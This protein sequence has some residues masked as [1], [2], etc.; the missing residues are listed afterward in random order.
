[1]LFQSIWANKLNLS[2]IYNRYKMKIA[3]LTCQNLPNLNLSDQQLIPT[4]A[5]HNIIATAAIWDDKSINWTL[6]DYLLFRNTWDYYEKENQF[7]TWLNHIQSLGIKTLNAIEII[8]KNKHKFYL[9]D[10]YNQ[11]ITILPTVFIEKTTTLNLAQIIPSHWKKA[12]IK[13]AFSAGSFQT[14]LF[15]VSQIEQINLQYQSIA[16][17][18]ELLLQ[19]YMPQIVTQGETSFIFFN[20]QFSHCVNKKPNEGDFR[21]QVQYGGKYT[22]IHPSQD[23]INQA[24]KIVN[25]F[26]DK[27][28]YARVDGIIINNQ[29]HLMEVECIEPDLYFNLSENSQTN[30][31]N[32][33]LELIQ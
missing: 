27:L 20:K 33:L 8:Q 29:L 25:T 9:R 13:P 5:K 23:L 14:Q 1:M 31:V 24:Q 10:F 7:N 32:A 4:L 21:I 12:V 16:Q 6:F 26:P 2:N 11:G 30:F 18:K 15:E 19:E 28:L 3:L 17:E 22:L